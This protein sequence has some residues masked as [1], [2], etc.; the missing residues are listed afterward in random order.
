MTKQDNELISNLAFGFKLMLISF[1]VIN[2]FGSRFE[3]AE[4]INNF[5]VFGGILIG[6]YMYTNGLVIKND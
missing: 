5:F 2:F 1:L 6:L 3:Y 4:V